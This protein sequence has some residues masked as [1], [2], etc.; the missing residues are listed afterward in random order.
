MQQQ[1]D[2]QRTAQAL[3]AFGMTLFVQGRVADCLA[4]L[5]QALTIWRDVNNQTRVSTVLN[6]L[7]MVAIAQNQLDQA[8]QR[9]DECLSIASS[10]G[11]ASGVGFARSN[12]GLVAL[13]RGDPV[14]ALAYFAQ[15]I[16]IRHSLCEQWTLAYSL[17]GFAAAMLAKASSSAARW[18]AA[19]YAARLSGVVD[20]LLSS[21]GARLVNTY[22]VVYH[23]TV[24]AA[25]N[26]LGDE[27]C[28]SARRRG[29]QAPFDEVLEAILVVDETPAAN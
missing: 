4:P 9:L 22:A 21:T 17:A 29:S 23:E 16:A 14:T 26:I 11:Y 19:H 1:G 8:Q 12:M 10:I 5:E 20:Q 27:A 15:S 28:D 6:N 3:V 18:Q 25:R 2:P 13:Q 24:A 7:A